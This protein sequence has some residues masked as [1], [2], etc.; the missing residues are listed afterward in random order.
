MCVRFPR[1]SFL[2]GL[3]L[4]G[5]A[6]CVAERGPSI[7]DQNRAMLEA[8]ASTE[9]SPFA[10]EA[11]SVDPPAAALYDHAAVAA[12]NPIASQI[13]VD[14]LQEGGNAVDAAVATALVLG[15]LNPF[16]SGIGGGGF[17][18]VRFTD[19]APPVALDFR[20]VAP[21][22]ATVDMYQGIAVEAAPS[23]TLG[24][25]AVAVPGEAMG[26]WTLHEAHGELP[27]STVVEP[28]L[29]LAR[30]GFPA[31]TL[32][33]QRL[34]QAPNLASHTDF[35]AAWMPDQQLPAEGDTI[36]LPDYAQFLERYQSLGPDAFYE[37]EV[38]EDIVRSV[39]GAGGVI[40]LEDL[41][42]YH[43]EWRT[44]L[45]FAWRDLTIIT[46]P[47]VSSGGVVLQ[48]VLSALGDE[49]PPGLWASPALFHRLCLLYGFAFADRA[50][51]LGDPS[52]SDLQLES[53]LGSS[54]IAE[55]R[56]ALSSPT[57]LPTEAFGTLVAPVQDDGTSHISVVDENGMAVALTTTINTAFG[58]HVR[59]EQFG[60]VLN[61]EMDDFSASPGVP[62]AFGL[63][64]SFA[65]R[66]EPGKRPLSSMTPTIVERT[67]E[68]Q[69]VLGAS[70]GPQIITGTL[71]VLL[72]LVWYD[73]TVESAVAAPRMHFQW[74]PRTVFLEDDGAADALTAQGWP[75]QQVSFGSAVQAIW[76]RDGRWNAAS[77]PRKYGRAAGY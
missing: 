16:A 3:T 31:G 60:I 14:I 61:N 32:L 55:I 64:G 69:G 2:L 35:F 67:G 68:V 34:Q 66:I 51:L 17:A 44:P 12:D 22:A 71:S 75:T 56:T 70:G 15:V 54:R 59:T 18:V 13:G 4:L 11:G 33:V 29:E 62:N 45:Q 27:W 21:A 1:R 77:D 52:F 25:L 48:Q 30:D 43:P 74:L 53:M 49:A 42:A 41:T 20:E 36:T 39:N 26:L 50:L 47:P 37:G 73:E 23:S 65:N 6:A 57:A 8:M 19:G 10:V 9:A 72:Q 5:L 7:Q 58:S 28:A 63:I 38:A 46:M 40:T 76:R 24:G